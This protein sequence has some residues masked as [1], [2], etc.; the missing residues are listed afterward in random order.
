MSRL[1]LDW[2]QRRYIP[3][4]LAWVEYARTRY[5]CPQLGK[6]LGP[7]STVEAVYTVSIRIPSKTVARFGIIGMVRWK[8][9]VDGS[10]WAQ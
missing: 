9:V 4:L 7:S 5:I 1:G 6:S 10:E 8:D 3:H 2:F